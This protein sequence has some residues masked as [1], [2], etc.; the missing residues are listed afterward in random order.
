MA[1]TSR[2]LRELWRHWLFKVTRGRSTRWS[3]KWRNKGHLLKEDLAE[4]FSDIYA[5]NYWNRGKPDVPSS[6]GGSSLKATTPLRERL[7]G[8]AA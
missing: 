5:N 4:R 7:P 8:A 6:G 1:T 2:N 3:P